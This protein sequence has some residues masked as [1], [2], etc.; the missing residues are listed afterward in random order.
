MQYKHWTLLGMVVSLLFGGGIGWLAAERIVRKGCDQYVTNTLTI[1]RDLHDESRARLAAVLEKGEIQKAKDM[2]YAVL[3]GS[4]GDLASSADANERRKAC[5]LLELLG[6]NVIASLM[7]G[8]D[9]GSSYR[10]KFAESVR[11]AVAVCPGL[12]PDQTN[13]QSSE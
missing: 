7:K 8:G 13:P 11:E 4:L 2:V 3:G 6:P 10:R 5:K 1:A 12:K 9:V